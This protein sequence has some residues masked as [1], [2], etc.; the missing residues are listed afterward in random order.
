MHRERK[1]GCRGKRL[2]GRIV[3]GSIGWRWCHAGIGWDAVSWIVR[4]RCGCRHSRCRGPITVADA[5]LAKP[6]P[7]TRWTSELGLPT[8]AILQ[9]PAKCPPCPCLSFAS[10][11]L[12]TSPFLVRTHNLCSTSARCTTANRR[13]TSNYRQHISTQLPGL[14]AALFLNQSSALREF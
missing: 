2:R 8:C 4:K 11:A 1:S 6:C 12:E 7:Q 3:C 10:V 14:Y 13:Q 9:P 5:K